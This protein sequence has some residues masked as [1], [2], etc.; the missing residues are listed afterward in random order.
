MFVRW[1]TFA[2]GLGLML[3]PLAVGYASAGAVLHDVALGLLVCAASVVALGRRPA[4]YAL[5]APA[6]WLMAVARD[7]A[8]ARAAIPPLA[9]GAILLVLAALPRGHA[10]GAPTAPRLPRNGAHA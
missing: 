7:R 5:A 4:R 6:V 9:A 8:D 10:S 1:G 2:V 3:A